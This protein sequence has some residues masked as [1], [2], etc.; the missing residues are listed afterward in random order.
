[1]K[2][3]ATLSLGTKRLFYRDSEPMH[4]LIVGQERLHLAHPASDYQYVYN[5]TSDT[6]N[7]TTNIPATQ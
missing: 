6:I 5:N 7:C 3:L 2:V 1:M 4:R